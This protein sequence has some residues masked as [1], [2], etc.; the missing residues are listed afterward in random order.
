MERSLS[1]NRL[2]SI[3]AESASN[4]NNNKGGRKRASL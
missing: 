1:Q 2:A 3:R 4:N